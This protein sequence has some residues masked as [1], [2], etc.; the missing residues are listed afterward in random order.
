MPQAF[1]AADAWNIH[2]SCVVMG[3]AFIIV[4]GAA[5]SGK[6][7]LCHELASNEAR[8]VADDRLV[9]S[10]KE[11]LFYFSAPKT[12]HGLAEQ[13]GAGPVPID[14]IDP[15]PTSENHIVWVELAGS[16]Q[17][18]QRKQI[19]VLGKEI[20]CLHL[21]QRPTAE[22]ILELQAHIRATRGVA[23]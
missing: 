3:R 5:G 14:A 23:V 12:L 18:A 11:G 10:H 7:S 15:D 16:A 2:A 1:R 19:S 8:W 6:T 22:V 9:I 20:G 17:L 4:S 21:P 13:P